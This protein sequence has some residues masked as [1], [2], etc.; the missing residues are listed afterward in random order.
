MDTELEETAMTHR[1]VRVAAVSVAGFAASLVIGT[2]SAAAGDLTGTLL[3]EDPDDLTDAEA[4]VV[5]VVPPKGGL[6]SPDPFDD[7][8]TTS[9]EIDL[10]IEPEPE[11][12][13]SGTANAL[14]VS[15]HKSFAALGGE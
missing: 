9:D 3:L 15:V 13:G 14:I 4:D 12:A 1:L 11:P 7:L 2:T 6:T 10:F 5:L 8:P